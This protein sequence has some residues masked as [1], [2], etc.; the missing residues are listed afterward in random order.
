MHP[1]VRFHDQLAPGWEAKYDKPSF[2]ERA[3]A[4]LSLL[5]HRDLQGQR[6]LDAG[7]GSGLLSRVLAARGCHVLGVDGSP[8]MVQAAAS[9]GRQSLSPNAGPLEFERVETVEALPMANGS[10]D[11]VLCSS[12]I[13]YLDH[14]RQCLEEFRRVLRPGGLLLLSVPNRLSLI[15]RALKLS[16]RLSQMLRRRPWPEYLLWSRNEY[17]L[18]E[19]VAL[20]QACGFE[21]KHTCYYAPRLP[22]LLSRSVVS[23]TLIIALVQKGTPPAGIEPAESV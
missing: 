13:E 16:L 23:G 7:C 20:L 10:F 17:S 15:R 2:R 21:I 6:W 22:G 12:V 4:L 9:I 14:P 19:A 11:G 1:A 3:N 5:D 18:R 8:Q